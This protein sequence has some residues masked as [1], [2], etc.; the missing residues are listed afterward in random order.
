MVGNMSKIL[1][2]TIAT[3]KYHHFVSP[4][5]ESA[6]ENFFPDIGFDVLVFSDRPKDIPNEVYTSVWYHRPWPYPT[7]L[8]YHAFLSQR[9]LLSSYDY[10]FYCDIDMLFV[11]EVS[12]ILHDGI[13]ATIHPG[14]Y[15]KTRLE[16]TYETNPNSTAYISP[17]EGIKYF[18]GGFNG[19]SSSEFLKMSDTICKNINSDLENNIVA[20][21]HDES[22]LNKYLS[23]YDNIRMLDPSYCFP[24][25]L[26]AKDLPFRK[27]L[28]ALDKNHNE[29]RGLI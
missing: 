3:G 5:L 29:L 15:N 7:L 14:F 18:A 2:C 10:V 17:N 22:H 23:N 13:V 16:Y 25:A 28:M 12:D 27:R 21:W 26:W 4:L 11:D 9:S 8:R 20:V 24:E 1:L 6:K 19:G